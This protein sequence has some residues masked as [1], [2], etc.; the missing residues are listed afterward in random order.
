MAIRALA[1]TTTTVVLAATSAIIVAPASADPAIRGTYN[2]TSPTRV[3]DTRSGIGVDGTR[4]LG[5]GRAITFK[6]TVG[7]SA[8]SISAVALTITAVSPARSGHLTVYPAE[9]DRSNI[10]TVNFRAGRTA[11]NMTIMRVPPSVGTVVVY[12]GSKG[13]VHVLADRMGYW[14]GESPTIAG[15]YRPVSPFRKLDT[16]GAGGAPAT[17][18]TY[19]TVQVTGHGVPAGTAAVAINLTAVDPTRGGFLTA[20]PDRQGAGRRTSTVNFAAGETRANFAVV[21][22][23]SA[24]AFTLYAGTRGTVHELVD[25]LG[26][27]NGGAPT[28]DGAYEPV[29]V[30]RVLDTRQSAPVAAGASR[31]VAIYPDAASVAATQALV[32]TVTVITPQRGGHLT[33]WDGATSLPAVSNSSFAAGQTVAATV[34]VPV[35][36]DGTITVHNGSA[37]RIELA[38]DL[39][40]TTVRKP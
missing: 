31:R 30:R 15:G 32:V 14:T 7:L 8:T 6:A 21:P 40:G 39:L 22:L 5:P 19:R 24:G 25:V 37:G 27:F 38:V 11:A 18:G 23:N 20:S 29:A 26:Y 16:R 17:G 12:N 1:R 2:P 10:S 13:T 9:T 33:A 34:I 4:P 28:D 36:R 35:N 3:L